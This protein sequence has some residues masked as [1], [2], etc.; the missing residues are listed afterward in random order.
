MVRLNLLPW[1][2]RQRRAAVRRFQ[3]ALVVSLL[4]AFCGV[5]LLDHLARQRLQQQALAN[6]GRQTAV[7]SL[8]TQLQRIAALQEARDDIQAQYA[9]LAEL[10]A[11]QGLVV[12]MFAEFE[13]AMPGGL[14]LTELTLQGGRLQVVG[15]AASPAVLAQ[16]MRDLERAPVLQGLELKQLRHLPQGDEFQLVARLLAS[17]S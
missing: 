14:H 6:A 8:E 12:A 15:V 3:L 17:W 10:R 5:M 7:E 4:L 1:R 2:E 9:A 13:R 11:G 16:L